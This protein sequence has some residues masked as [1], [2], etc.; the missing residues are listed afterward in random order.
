MRV[1]QLWSNARLATLR[2][3][4]PGLGVMEDGLIA[5]TGES[6]VYA[7]PRAEAPAFDAGTVH[8]CAGRWITP[9]LIDCHTHLVYA[10]N[11]AREFELRLAGASYEAIARAGGG[12]V[13]TMTATRAASRE[14]LIAEALPRLDAMLVEGLTTVE[15]KSG[16]G[17]SPADEIKMLEAARA[18]GE[19]RR[20]GIAATFLGAHALPPEFAGDPDGYVDLVC[21]EM[22]PAVAG[23]ADAVDAFCEGI[24]FNTDQV[25]RV[26]EAA[27]AH[28]LPVKLHAEQLS[29]LHGAALA[30]AFG[31]LSADHL[32]HLDEAGIDA[33][34]RAGTVA[35]LLPGAFYFTREA[36]LPPIDALRTA[37]VP[38]A[39]ATDCNPGTSPLT[40]P[41]L[42]MNMAA[43]LFRLTVDECIAGMTRE[44]A[45]A[46]GRLDTIGTL[47]PG[48]R[49]DLAIWDIK[50]P[51]ELVYRM[52]F[53]PL[54]ARIFGGRT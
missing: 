47:E 51:A 10:G 49:C 3:D 33:M 30:A 44:A 2:G 7:G 14:Q 6:I 25:R 26:F 35:V 34:A 50:E 19:A 43:T 53:N 41:L 15:I 29:N 36:R 38:I 46:L 42:A 40:S 21:N 52:G 48:K 11:R 54:H 4:L 28:G 37:G 22:I 24:G 8:D 45:R 31:A 27:A 9:G 20:V 32:E 23:L 39:V 18:L 12:I 17:L 16:Y 5:A 13:S 1:E